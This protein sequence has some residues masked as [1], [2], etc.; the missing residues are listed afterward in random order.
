MHDEDHQHVERGGAGADD[1][2]AEPAGQRRQD[3]LRG[4]QLGHRP[5]GRAAGAA[6]EPVEPRGGAARGQAVDQPGTQARPGP[7]DGPVGGQLDA[8]GEVV[9]GL[10]GQ[11]L[12]ARED[13]PA[14]Q[15]HGGGDGQGGREH[16]DR[17]IVVIRT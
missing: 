15:G 12:R 11:G 13:R 5:V 2:H 1:E 14:D 7:A 6:G 8:A 17:E 3:E 4:D 10:R 16:G 9:A